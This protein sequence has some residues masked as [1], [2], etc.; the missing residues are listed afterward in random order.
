MYQSKPISLGASVLSCNF[1]IH[2]RHPSCAVPHDVFV[3]LWDTAGGDLFARLRPLVRI[4]SL[5]S[6]IAYWYRSQN[7]PQ[8]NAFILCYSLINYVSL[9]NCI[10][11]WLPEL[12]HH[13][14]NTPIILCGTK[15]DLVYADDQA[16]RVP[17]ELG[18]EVREHF[19]R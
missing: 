19:E 3:A 13:C 14:P 18:D 9:K 17:I 6:A 16:G 15:E 7:Y 2:S 12:K 1:Q 10:D 11:V 5:S 4:Y 8:T